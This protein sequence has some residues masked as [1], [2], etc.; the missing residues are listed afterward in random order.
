MTRERTGTYKLNHGGGKS[1][2]VE[3]SIIKS[4]GLYKRWSRFI[5]WLFK[6]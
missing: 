6:L 4:P 3:L 5:A 1:Y 2:Y